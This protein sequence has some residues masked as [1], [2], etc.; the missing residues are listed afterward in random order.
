MSHSSS[1]H[2]TKQLH[3]GRNL[4]KK[5]QIKFNNAYCFIL[6]KKKN[7]GSKCNLCLLNQGSPTP[8]GGRPLSVRGLLG[9]GP[10]SRRWS[11]GERAKLHLPLP[12]AP[13]CSC[14]RLSHLPPPYSPGPPPPTVEKLSS[15]KPVPGAKKVGDLCIKLLYIGEQSVRKAKRK[16]VISRE[17]LEVKHIAQQPL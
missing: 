6:K 11:A 9:T 14:Y 17:E 1:S 7:F 4:T 2:S 15:T 8:P 16:D 3:S 5:R 13:H 10:H 12:M